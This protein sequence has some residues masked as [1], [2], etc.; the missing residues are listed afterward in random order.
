MATDHIT[1]RSA[2]VFINFVRSHLT[3]SASQKIF[4]YEKIKSER[5]L[6]EAGKE[7]SRENAHPNIHDPK[8][9]HKNRLLFQHAYIEHKPGETYS[10]GFM[11]GY[12]E[13][14]K[15]KDIDRNKFRK[16]QNLGVEFIVTLSPQAFEHGEVPVDSKQFELWVNTSLDFLKTNLGEERI[17][18]IT[19]H[20]D[21]GS[22][23]IHCI[24]LP[25]ELKYNKYRECEIFTICARDVL[26]Y[27][28]FADLSNDL[29]QRLSFLNIKPSTNPTKRTHVPVRELYGELK[30]TVCIAREAI[31]KVEQDLEES[32]VQK[33]KELQK[34]KEQQ[35]AEL[36][37]ERMKIIRYEEIIKKKV[38]K[39]LETY[40]AFAIQL[41]KIKHLDKQDFLK[42]QQI[43]L[44]LQ[45]ELAV[46][47][48]LSTSIEKT[49]IDS[50]IPNDYATQSTK[51]VL[52]TLLSKQSITQNLAGA[53]I[54]QVKT[55]QQKIAQQNQT[56]QPKPLH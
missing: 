9:R 25:I 43:K 10:K 56:P 49:F 52:D 1:Q 37:N 21:E 50:D 38:L 17:L 33:E 18:T 36:A 40:I 24:M 39:H 5:Q 12:R 4:R 23:H 47:L 51:K 46:A 55:E 7:V 11:R 53:I 34:K 35:E 19:L 41:S 26:D 28:N 42:N 27:K 32:R 22:A 31:D 14:L 16:D 45:T 15:E 3:K 29:D 2:D 48:N 6:R 20:L 44:K 13:I 30:Q 8:S 54:R